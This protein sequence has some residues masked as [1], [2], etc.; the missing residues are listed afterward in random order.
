[1]PPIRVDSTGDVELHMLFGRRSMHDAVAAVKS[2]YRFASHR[3]PLVVHEDGSLTASDARFLGQQLPGLRIIPRS[4]A[5]V[6][7][8][9]ELRRANLPRCAE[10]RQ[11]L[12]LSLKYFDLQLYA[13]GKSVLYL[14]SDVLFHRSPIELQTALG[15]A[16]SA[17]VDRY[18]VDINTAYTWPAADMLRVTGVTVPPR[19]NSGLM[20]VRRE[21]IDWTLAE[22]CLSLGLPP[23]AIHFAEQT[24][25]AIDLAHRGARPLAPEYDVCFRNVW[26]GSDYAAWLRTAVGYS[27]VVSQHYCGGEAQRDYFYRHVLGEA[28]D[29]A[30][31]DDA[32]D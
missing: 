30:S 31:P 8:G 27:N 25:W 11:K 9:A 14:D 26:T 16:P 5:D 22:E 17:W 21:T 29:V 18:N 23:S 12:V 3:Y 32:R 2:F 7:V 6:R 28:D 24:L 13:A 10:L 15:T 19:I 20:C 4:E 1:M